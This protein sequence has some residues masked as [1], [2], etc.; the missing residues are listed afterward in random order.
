MLSPMSEMKAEIP[1]G[2]NMAGGAPAGMTST[3]RSAPRPVEANVP[4]PVFSP[5]QLNARLARVKLL[6]C[7][8]DGILTDGSVFMGGGIEYKRFDIRDGLGLRLLQRCGVK[9]GWISARPSE[10]TRQRA[11]DLKIDFLAQ[12]SNSKVETAAPLLAAHAV[13][14]EEVCYLG[15]DVVDLG[16]LRRAGVAVSVPDAVA[17]AKALAHYVTQNR[18]GHGAVREVVELI[19]TAQNHWP[20]VIE[21]FSA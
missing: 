21:E 10:A 13:Q 12:S 20:R 2:L 16:M 9:V 5:S 3:A 15:D 11:D 7:D 6:L 19:L 14:W 1:A 4:R 17:E 18:G 8:V